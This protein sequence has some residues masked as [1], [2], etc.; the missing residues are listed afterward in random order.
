[1]LLVILFVFSGCAHLSDHAL[2]ISEEIGVMIDQREQKDYDLIDEHIKQKRD[3]ADAWM[4]AVTIPREIKRQMKPEM[5]EKICENCGTHESAV[6]LQN[7][8]E[9][10]MGAVMKKRMEIAAEI[11][12]ADTALRKP[13]RVFY[14]QLRSLHNAL[15]SNI[16]SVTKSRQFRQE[17]LRQMNVDTEKLIPF[18]DV[19]KKLQKYYDI[20]E[21]DDEMGK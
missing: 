8:M 5:C 20:L 13:V 6:Y 21:D 9:R 18:K 16:K 19:D 4:K 3:F 15:H 2:P 11:D 10:F 12:Q 17:I 1:M 14:T 7:F